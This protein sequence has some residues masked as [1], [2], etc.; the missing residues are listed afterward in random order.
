MWRAHI[1]DQVDTPFGVGKTAFLFGP[2]GGWQEHMAVFVGFDIAIGVLHHQEF[3]FL[4]RFA[5]AWCVGHGGHRVGGDQPQALDLSGFNR[6]QD[7]GHE[8]AAFFGEE[9]FID[10]PELG[11]VLAVLIVFQRAVT[12]QTGTG[13]PFTSTHGIALSGDGETRTAG[14]ADISGD[15]V[16][17]VDRDHAIR[18]MRTLVDAHGPD[19]HGG[20]GIAVDACHIANGVFVDAADFRC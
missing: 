14:L 20:T 16:Q 6:G 10:A 4:Q 18:T 1:A 15:Q 13:R 2:H 12:R 11:D 17:V 5:D 9:V 7:I 8:Q 19:G 3:Q